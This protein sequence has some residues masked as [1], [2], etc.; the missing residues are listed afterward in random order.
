[1]FPMLRGGCHFSKF[2]VTHVLSWVIMQRKVLIKLG[3]VNL[4]H[5]LHVVDTRNIF[6]KVPVVIML[7]QVTLYW[8]ISFFTFIIN[9]AILTVTFFKY[10]VILKKMSKEHCQIHF[11]TK[12]WFIC[13]LILYLITTALHRCIL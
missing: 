10:S 11:L 1:M 7:F 4:E 3:S 9:K 6:W 2:K 13:M 5:S 8:M 12:E